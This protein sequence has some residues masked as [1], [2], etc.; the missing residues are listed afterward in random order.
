MP[1][2][3][4]LRSGA[5]MLLR[6]L[7]MDRDSPRDPV[8]DAVALRVDTESSGIVQVRG[9]WH[10]TRLRHSRPYDFCGW[11]GILLYPNGDVQHFVRRSGHLNAPIYGIEEFLSQLTA[12]LPAG[13]ET[14][15]SVEGAADAFNFSMHKF[16]DPLIVAGLAELGIY[17]HKFLSRS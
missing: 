4:P 15:Y 8:L 9:E 16:E 3:V 10:D 11:G 5:F 17:R 2:A 14:Y 7:V 1:R 6:G 13:L 12:S